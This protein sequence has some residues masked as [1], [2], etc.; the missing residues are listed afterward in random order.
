MRVVSLVAVFVAA[1]RA[2]RSGLRAKDFR[3]SLLAILQEKTYRRAIT[4]RQGKRPR[5]T[6]APDV[7]DVLG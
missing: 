7:A 2:F 6:A 4:A 1:A 3:P 5:T